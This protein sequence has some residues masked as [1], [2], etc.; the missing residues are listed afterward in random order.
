MYVSYLGA[1]ALQA[2]IVRS[3]CAVLLPPG[4]SGTGGRRARQASP[5]ESSGPHANPVVSFPLL[6][7][8]HA[9]SWLAA[10]F[11][12]ASSRSRAVWGRQA[13]PRTSRSG[14]SLD[15]ALQRGLRY[16]LGA[17]DSLQDSRQ[18]HGEAIA[19]RSQLLPNL[20]GR[21]AWKPRSKSIWLPMVSSSNFRP[22]LGFSFPTVDGPIQLF[23]SARPLT[24]SVADLQAIRTYQSSREAQRAA[25]LSAGTRGKWWSTW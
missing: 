19:A 18:A 20:S 16:N 7:V 24:Q 2:L 8:V 5:E 1:T 15:D 17:V 12:Q 21:P 3:D 4:I 22:S 10:G 14:L 6:D 23:R 25:E 11:A 9:R 13:S